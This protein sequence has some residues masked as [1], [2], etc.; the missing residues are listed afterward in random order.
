MKVQ[1]QGF[2]YLILASLGFGSMGTIA[3][4]AYNQGIDTNTLL[5]FRFSLAAIT[6]WLI[7]ALGKVP[8]RV[9]RK[10]LVNLLLLGVIGYTSMSTLLFKSFQ[11]ISPAMATLVFYTYPLMVV[12]FSFLLGLEKVSKGKIYSLLAAGVGLILVLQANS[13]IKWSGIIYSIIAAI[14]YSAFIL[15]SRERLGGNSLVNSAYISLFTSITLFLIGFWYHPIGILFSITAWETMILLA[16]VSTII[17]FLFFFE[18]LKKL[19]ASKTAII[20]IVEP[21][22]AV[23]LSHVFFGEQ[24]TILQWVGL[25]C[26]IL[27]S[28]TVSID[29]NQFIPKKKLGIILKE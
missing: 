24:L 11:T 5:F 2:S 25:S 10:E 4:F 29:V 21:V 15:I 18:G 13:E 17:P 27:T 22:F 1:L 16:V 6:L 14:I 8:F 20:S 3:I 9:N 7:I 28:I 23:F 26:V 12:F 19:D